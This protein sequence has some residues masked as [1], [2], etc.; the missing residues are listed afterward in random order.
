MPCPAW[1]K[2]AFCWRKNPPLCRCETVLNLLDVLH[3]NLPWQNRFICSPTCVDSKIEIFD[4]TRG[5]T[6]SFG[7]RSARPAL[8]AASS[9]GESHA[10]LSVFKNWNLVSLVIS[11]L[12]STHLQIW[13]CL[14]APILP[15]WIGIIVESVSRLSLQWLGL[16]LCL[17]WKLCDELLL[18]C[19][20]TVTLCC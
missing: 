14:I 3:S 1:A 13:I 17:W 4:R 20:R 10:L 2:V 15:I 16:S 18:F 7:C 19:C 9:I 12:L 6:S 11:R 8:Q 5:H